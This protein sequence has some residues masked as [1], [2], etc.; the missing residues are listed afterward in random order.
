VSGRMECMEAGLHVCGFRM[1]MGRCGILDNS[2]SDQCHD[3]IWPD[4]AVC[5]CHPL[6]PPLPHTHTHTHTVV[7]HAAPPAMIAARRAT[8]C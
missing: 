1:A 2:L 6:P 8:L 3:T 4:Q 5:V 7:D